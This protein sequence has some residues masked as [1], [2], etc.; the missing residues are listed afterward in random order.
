MDTEVAEASVGAET[1]F[2]TDSADAGFLSSQLLALTERTARR[3]RSTGVRGRTVSI[4]V[5][6]E[7]FSTVTRSATLD[8]PVDGSRAVYAAAT[9]LLAKARSAG[10]GA[11]RIRLLGVR[12][13]NLVASSESVEQ[14]RLG[15]GEPEPGWREVQDAVDRAVA[16]FGSSAI[17][18]ATLLGRPKQPPAGKPS[19]ES[20]GNFRSR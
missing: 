20:R 6:F 7:D 10:A 11:R 9:E 14:L 4:K 13:E 5:R 15:E 16:R 18:P 3:A 12:L 8:T 1:T 2:A 19:A 17:G